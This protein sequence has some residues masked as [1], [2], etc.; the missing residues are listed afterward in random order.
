M[1]RGNRVARNKKEPIKG[2]ALV[3][4]GEMGQSVKYPVKYVLCKPNDLSSDP[5]AWEKLGKAALACHSSY[6]SDG[7]CVCVVT[8]MA[9]GR[10]LKPI[11]SSSQPGQTNELQV[12]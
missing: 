11:T 9:T 6:S 8:A 12:Q 4:A 10:F 1:E 5:Q 2:G 7:V 3:G